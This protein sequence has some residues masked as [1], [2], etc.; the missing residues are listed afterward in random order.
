MEF[1]DSNLDRPLFNIAPDIIDWK[2]IVF[3]IGKFK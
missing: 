1:S 3:E 2:Q